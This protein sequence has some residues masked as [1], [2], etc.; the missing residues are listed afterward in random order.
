MGEGGAEGSR[1]LDATSRCGRPRVAPVRVLVI[2]RRP[3][4]LLNFTPVLRSLA[5]RGHRV[6]I[7]L[8]DESE[9]VS[10]QLG[11]LDELV[12]MFPGVSRC[13]APAGA[14]RLDA[15][16]RELRLGLDALRYREP[17]YAHSPWLRAH[18]AERVP[19]YMRRLL[20]ARAIRRP[21]ARSAVRALLA[22]LERAA[23]VPV[24]V[25]AFLRQERADVVAVVPLIVFGGPQTAYVRGS[26]HLRM[27]TAGWI[28]S[29]DNLTSKGSI[30]EAPDRLMVWNDAQRREAVELHGV[31]AERVAVTG[32]QAWDHWFDWRPSTTREEFCLRVGLRPDRPY[33]L[34]LGS[35]GGGLGLEAPFLTRWIA[36]MRRSTLPRIST[37]GVL[38]RPHPWGKPEQWRALEAGDE[39]SVFPRSGEQPN[40]AQARAD[41]FDSIHHSAAVAGANSSTFIESAI[42]GRPVLPVPA[43][44]FRTAQVGT[45]HFS[46]FQ[47]EG[48]GLLS[49]PDSLDEHLVELD[50]ALAGDPAWE[51]RRRRFL[52]AFVRPHGLDRPATP[53][54]VAAMED[55]AGQRPPPP[56]H[57]GV[58]ARLGIAALARALALE[59][60]TARGRRRVRRALR[61]GRRRG[62]RRLRRA[63]RRVRRATGRARP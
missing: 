57:G 41:F 39:V 40:S 44:E 33:V 29:W 23:P 61:R 36:A 31:P 43:P 17:L 1:A 20:G 7:A 18:A 49:L 28:Y 4:Y 45:P 30:H 21:R 12:Q 26:R 59:R 10:G 60:D 32:A 13:A 15:T 62:V 47:R 38:V 25:E 51:E 48:G 37:A 22:G 34:Y 53:R 16:A 63:H 58:L 19:A 24:E 35:S 2:A 42:V 5:E 14:H 27:A 54:F 9:R 50:A 11:A 8:E 6:R 52:E 46:Y 55:L 56:R 3:A